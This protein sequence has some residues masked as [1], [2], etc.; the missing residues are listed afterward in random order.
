MK[1][2]IIGHTSGLGQA[3]YKNFQ[4]QSW[5]VV[6]LTRS[7]GYDATIN[8]K[9]IVTECIDADLVVLSSYADGRQAHL[10]ELLKDQVKNIAVCGSIARL[11]PF[12]DFID[13]TYVKDKEHL[14]EVCRL[15]SISPKPYANILHIDISFLEGPT[16]FDPSDPSNFCPD[17]T[18]EFD[19]V[20]AIINFWLKHPTI[21]QVEFNWKLTPFL[22]TCLKNINKESQLLATLESKI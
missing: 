3:F 5:E 19:E 11:D 18:I 13:S 12:T 16:K 4:S 17:Y 10:V 9:G 7:N 6:G 15:I 20:V 1:C 14:A 22:A 8:S 21:R 2:V